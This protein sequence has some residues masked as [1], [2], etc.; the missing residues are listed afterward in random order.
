M[1]GPG[2][3]GSLTHAEAARGL[4]DRPPRCREPQTSQAES[5]QLRGS[6]GARGTGRDEAPGTQ[7]WSA[8]LNTCQ[9][10]V[11]RSEGEG[12][13]R[14]LALVTGGGGGTTFKY[15]FR[16]IH[17]LHGRRL[18]KKWESKTALYRDG[19]LGTGLRVTSAA[20]E[21]HESRGQLSS[22]CLPGLSRLYVL[23]GSFLSASNCKGQ[24]SGLSLRSSCAVCGCTWGGIKCVMCVG[25]CGCV[26]WGV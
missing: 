12:V 1:S 3:R 25:V 26:V 6:R 8:R 15:V 2:G 22:F 20:S 9:R 21:P 4:R 14:L 19:H 5:G 7:L 16:V 11:C 24:K 13:C 23:F 18:M 10:T 17:S